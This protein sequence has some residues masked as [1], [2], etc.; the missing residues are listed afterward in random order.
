M[1]ES[2]E[3]LIKLKKIWF[4]NSQLTIIPKSV[5][6]LTNFTALYLY[7]NEITFLPES[8]EK[9]VNLTTLYLY[10]EQITVDSEVVNAFK[11]AI[12]KGRSVVTKADTEKIGKI[13]RLGTGCKTSTHQT[14]RFC[15]DIFTFSSESAKKAM[16][17]LIEVDLDVRATQRAEA[18][19]KLKK[20]K[21]K[22]TGEK[23]TPS[24]TLI[25]IYDELK[26]I[27]GQITMRTAEAFY[28]KIEQL[29]LNN[30]YTKNEA[31]T[32]M[33]FHDEEVFTPEADKY[34]RYKM[35]KFV[36]LRNF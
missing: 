16:E 2:V 23:N 34:I 32:L 3:N 14:L 17:A 1:P 8:I 29:F 21:E 15:T 27:H 24:N 12:K 28:A 35:R 33:N 6:N 19:A 25:A 20:V 26:N 9:L 10:D 4:D 22:S 13:L 36:A 30:T 7:S 5:G 31:V 18:I 11:D